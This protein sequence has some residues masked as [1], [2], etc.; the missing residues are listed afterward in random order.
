MQR[1]ELVVEHAH[2]QR[3]VV[4]AA[5]VAVL[6]LAPLFDETAFEVA[7]D[8]AGVVVPLPAVSP[9]RAVPSIRMDRRGPVK[10]EPRRT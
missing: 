9:Q 1:S 7:G 2:D 3:V 6:A 10:P 8:A 5:A 4:L